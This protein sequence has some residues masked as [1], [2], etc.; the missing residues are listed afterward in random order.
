M[1]ASDRAQLEQLKSWVEE[2][3]MDPSYLYV[4]YDSPVRGL[5]ARKPIAVRAAAH[6]VSLVTRHLLLL[7][8][9][10]CLPPTSRK[11]RRSSAFRSTES[12][13]S[14]LA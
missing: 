2:R 5:H 3:G 6:R 8:V 1:A 14:L 13:A 10:T 4:N 12:C 7:V 11:A 9:L